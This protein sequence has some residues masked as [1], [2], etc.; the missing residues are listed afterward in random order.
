MFTTIYNLLSAI[1]NVG[2]VFGFY[3]LFVKKEEAF[4]NHILAYAYFIWAL[5]DSM[6]KNYLMMMLWEAAAIMTF[7]K[8]V[9][10]R[11]AK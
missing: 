3:K 8:Y 9:K 10:N 7:V 1:G 6:E 4:A 2:V 11:E 5:S